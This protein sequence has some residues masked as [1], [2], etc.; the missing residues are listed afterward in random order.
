MK[1]LIP[2]QRTNIRRRTFVGLNG[3]QRTIFLI[4]WEYQSESE[5]NY[6]LFHFENFLYPVFGLWRKKAR[7]TVFT[8]FSTV[9][10][11][12]FGT[13]A[14]KLSHLNMNNLILKQVE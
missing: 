8:P 1:R 11:H 13:D 7:S 4:P 9:F 2:I 14:L 3:S 5:F 6:K 10:I 12:S